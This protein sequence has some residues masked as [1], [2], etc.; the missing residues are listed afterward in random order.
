MWPFGA[1]RV[2]ETPEERRS[3]ILGAFANTLENGESYGVVAPLRT[4][5]DHKAII[6]LVVINKLTE[7]QR[8][9]QYDVLW[10]AALLLPNFQEMTDAEEEMLSSL[11][12]QLAVI[13]SD[14]T[15]DD[16]AETLPAL[17]LAQR[18]AH[19]IEAERVKW[20]RTLA[21]AGLHPTGFRTPR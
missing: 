11:P 17:E 8:G 12:D 7:A 5:E 10:A 20:I 19:Q 4:L 16:I 1:K 15:R 21:E 18:F 13:S 2:K 9:P 3:R 6:E 14:L